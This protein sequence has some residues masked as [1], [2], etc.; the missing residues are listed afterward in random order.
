MRHRTAAPSPAVPRADD[1]QITKDLPRI[2]VLETP[3]EPGGPCDFAQG[4]RRNGKPLAVMSAGKSR[5]A[6]RKRLAQPRP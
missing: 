5:L 2:L 4:G 1:R 3:E 6:S